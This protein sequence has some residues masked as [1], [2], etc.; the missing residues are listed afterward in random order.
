MEGTPSLWPLLIDNLH[1]VFSHQ[2]VFGVVDFDGLTG[3]A[4]K[5]HHVSIL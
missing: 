3:F 2:P 1:V 5:E 4:A